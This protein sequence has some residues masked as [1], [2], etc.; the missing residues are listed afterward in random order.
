MSKFDP[1]RSGHPGKPVA[2]DAPGVLMPCGLEGRGRNDAVFYTADHSVPVTCV[3]RPPADLGGRI[4]RARVKLREEPDGLL[5]VV[6]ARRDDSLDPL[7]LIPPNACRLPGVVTEFLGIVASIQ[8][9]ALRNVVRDTFEGNDVFENFWS[10]PAAPD[11]HRWKGGLAFHTL[12]VLRGVRSAMARSPAVG[13]PWSAVEQ[14]LALVAACLHDVA[15]CV[16]GGQ[17]VTN[18]V[19]ARRHACAIRQHRLVADALVQLSQDYRELA[20]ALLDLWCPGM[21]PQRGELR[22][23]AIRIL[24]LANHRASEASTVRPLPNSYAVLFDRVLG[25]TRH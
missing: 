21:P 25:V 11:H 22:V 19:E 17:P 4:W 16:D 9:P 23:N 3:L 12:E 24:M 18:E 14:D 13:L 8:T 15:E 1:P 5:T 6:S 10:V 20:N 2:L 7:S